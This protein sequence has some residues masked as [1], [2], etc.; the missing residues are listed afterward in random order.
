MRLF[1]DA[2][3]SDEAFDSTVLFA[4]LC[5]PQVFFY[6]MFVLVGQVLNAHRRFGR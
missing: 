6:G 1:V 4:R 5:L 2:D 3:W